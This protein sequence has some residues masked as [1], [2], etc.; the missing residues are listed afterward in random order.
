MEDITVVIFSYNSEKIIKDCI[1]TARLLSKRIILVDQSSTDKT[2]VIA[3]K[4]H[5]NVFKFF[6]HDYVEP[7]REFGINKST[8]DWVFILD[9]DERITPELAKEIKFVIS[10]PCLPAGMTQSS[11]FRINRKNIFINQWL[12][13][14]GWWPDSQIRL[15]N[16]QEFKTWP[17]EIHSTP[18]ISGKAGQ[19][20]NPLL[21]YF[22][23]DLKTMVDK[24]LIFE[25]IESEMLFQAGKP[26]STVMFFRKFL[27]EL[28]RRMFKKFGF[29]DGIAGVIE[30]IYQSFSKTIT[31]LLLYEK[32]QTC[33][34]EGRKV[35]LYNPFL[36]VLGGGEKH[37]LSIIKV[38]SEEGYLPYIYWDKDLSKE[39]SSR[40]QFKFSPGLKFLPNIFKYNH[41]PLT[42]YNALKAFDYLFYVT[43]GSYFFSSAKRN[44]V[45]AMVPDKKLY[46][47]DFINKLKIANYRFISNSVFTQ[48]RLKDFGISSDVIYPYID[49]KIINLSGDRPKEKIILSVGRFFSH[50]HSKRQDKMINLFKKI[51]QEHSLFKD[52][53]LILAGGLK[54]ED[55]EYYNQLTKLSGSDP[56]I[57]FKPNIPLH[58]LYELYEL[59]T[60]FWHFSG[61]EVDESTAP[62]RVEHFGLTPLEAMAAGCLTFCYRAGGLNETIIDGENGFLFSTEK[63]LID[64]MKAVM[65]NVEKQERIKKNAK[66]YVADNFSYT[67]FTERVKKII[68]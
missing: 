33:L 6:H 17:K 44:F 59:S 21:H 45:F 9:A 61:F 66:K 53:K 4:E 18:V 28:W 50:L 2:V 57:I 67:V 14:G 16:K 5:I 11:H 13:H 42:S 52:F 40:F 54:E 3:N 22:H 27:G 60:Y 56:S 63:E 25:N 48:K 34:P 51:K 31:Y 43:D 35:A 47:T 37:I 20:S 41:S 55:K 58:E 8:T 39:I 1:K 10:N 32:K 15:I 19:L 38:L 24:T 30:S 62:D 12:K 26:V 49:Q 7:A 29:L 23:G 68:L 65:N 36:D 46:H 64:K